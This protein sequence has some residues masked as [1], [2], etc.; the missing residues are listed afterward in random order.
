[1]GIILAVGLILILLGALLFISSLLNPRAGLGTLLGA[2]LGLAS[3]IYYGIPIIIVGLI[4]YVIGRLRE[5]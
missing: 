4:I 1:M 5:K 2:A 3:I